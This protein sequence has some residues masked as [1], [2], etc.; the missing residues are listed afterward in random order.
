MPDPGSLSRIPL[1]GAL[2][3]SMCMVFLLWQM[4]FFCE[5]IMH[6]LLFKWCIINS[7]VCVH[8][9][10]CVHACACSA[11]SG[12]WFFATPWTI[13][14]PAPLS[15]RFSWWEYWS[16]CH[17]LLQGSSQLSDRTHASCISY[18]GRRILYH[19]ATWEAPNSELIII[20][21]MD[22]LSSFENL[23]GLIFSN[24][25]SNPGPQEWEHQVLTT[26]PPGNSQFC[27]IWFQQ[28]D[29]EGI[30]TSLERVEM[31]LLA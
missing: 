27:H 26:G 1:V 11:V 31:T 16:G 30:T 25:G 9:Y 18:I 23:W 22:M 4:Y 17:F 20:I 21:I 24:Q 3:S 15:E 14:H 19:C 13:A 2:L 29:K 12:V 28:I 10:V 7:V 5:K 6:C 8:V